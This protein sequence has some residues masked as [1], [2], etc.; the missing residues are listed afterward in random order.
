MAVAPESVASATGTPSQ[1]SKTRR[2]SAK[3]TYFSAVL[4]AAAVL[5]FIALFALYQLRE[6]ALENGYATAETYARAFEDFVTQ[7]FNLT[8]LLAARQDWATVMADQTAAE[9][10][11]TL[12]AAILHVPSM[13]SLSLGTGGRIVASSNADN[14]GLE[15]DCRSF[16][17]LSQQL[18]LLRLGPPWTGRDFAGARESTPLAPISGTALAFLPLCYRLEAGRGLKLL[19]ALNPDFL[20]QHFDQA[21]PLD[22]GQV[23][24]LRIDGRRLLS[25]DPAQPM[26]D[27]S[28]HA[29]P[30]AG[31]GSGHFGRF[32]PTSSSDG[33]L[34]VYRSSSLYP[35]VVLVH[36]DRA[37]VLDNFRRTEAIVLAV[38]VPT[39]AVFLVLAVRYSRQRDKEF[40]LRLSMAQAQ[41]ANQAKSAFL[42]NMSHEI[43]T[44]MNAIL[45]M[46]WLALQTPLAPQQRDYV[47][48][49]ER[50]GKALLGI[51]NDVLDLSKVE[52]GKLVIERAPFRIGDV[53]ADLETQ[54]G[55]LAREKRIDF[56]VAVRADIDRPVLGDPLRLR[57][58]LT[59]LVGN[60]IKF[61]PE[62]GRVS[63]EV[64]A[65]DAPAARGQRPY[66]FAVRDSGIGMSAEQL[67]LLFQPFTQAEASTARR[68]GGTG[69]GL[70]ISQ[71]LARL[72]GGRI[73][74]ESTPGQ[75]SCFRLLLELEPAAEEAQSAGSDAL[76]S[77]SVFP[78][79]P[80]SRVLG[81]EISAVDQQVLTGARLLLVDDNAVNRQVAMG[82]LATL[83][84][85]PE[86]AAN[87]AEAIAQAERMLSE[88]GGIDVILMDVQMPDIDGDEV[89]RQLRTRAAFAQVPII[90]MTAYAMRSERERCLAAGM[91][92]HLAK[93]IDIAGL[94][95]VIARWVLPAL[96]R[97]G[98][99]E[100][101]S[102]SGNAGSSGASVPAAV[103]ESAGGPTIAGI[104][105][106]DGAYRFGQDAELFLS[107]LRE[108]GS[109]VL[110]HHGKLEQL[111]S[112]QD[113]AGAQALV[114]TVKGMAANVSARRLHLAAARL[115]ALLTP[116][117]LNASDAVSAQQ[118]Y[119]RAYDEVKA[120]LSALLERQEEQSG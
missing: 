112:S 97:P 50:A 63:L 113:V 49:I 57:Q 6:D 32:A 2:L 92:D 24:L 114:H 94:K 30:T 11:Q 53:I 47:L 60:A 15:I 99:T 56:Q 90:A 61:T 14:L 96:A 100:A 117:R 85:Q 66:C 48:Q 115:E 9:R 58:V 22:R 62:Q 44:P 80:D 69:L 75:G 18:G 78:E 105:L 28:P 72:M 110:A 76:S 83:G 77:G 8:E 3:W 102:G 89:T 31:V 109:S 41:R 35:V 116:E 29:V 1:P 39:L 103:A 95:R 54:I 73:E 43:R 4:G 98:E 7:T 106:A 107:V 55:F 33:L 108:S 104:D 71:R 87:G 93:P 86:Q 74:V 37:R 45:G 81:A 12:S 5:C 10:E 70:S 68:Y 34:S 91:N 59:N 13:R 25:T 46:S 23:E 38:I 118:E 67:K 120:G 21:L 36:L 17:P 27:V 79:M 111:L 119:S 82:M 42:A 51:I 101:D 84:I 64:T 20:I 26:G 52:A 65:P 88:S 16:L 40:E 19:G